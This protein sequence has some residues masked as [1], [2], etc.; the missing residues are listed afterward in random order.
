MAAPTFAL[1][2][3]RTHM[4]ITLPLPEPATLVA[5]CLL[6]ALAI[7]AGYIAF[8]VTRS[9]DDDRDFILVIVLVAFGALL[10]C[11]AA[12]AG[13]YLVGLVR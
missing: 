12:L 8:V 4:E 7:L 9:D 11:S 1:T 3:S 10:L 6:S 5:L 13:S 2:G